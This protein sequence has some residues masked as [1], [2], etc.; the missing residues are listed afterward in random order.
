MGT[1]LVTLTERSFIGGVLREPGYTLSV[2]EDALGTS[3]G[4]TADPS[5]PEKPAPV[6]LTPNLVPAST[7]TPPPAYQAAAIAPTGPNPTAPQA[8][9][10]DAVQ[11]AGGFSAPVGDSPADGSAAILPEGAET[12]PVP[13][14]PRRRGN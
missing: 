1:K 8:L 9:P 6:S 10:P 5:K 11:T 4:A 7:Y 12:A 14:A 2:D 13:T 3:I